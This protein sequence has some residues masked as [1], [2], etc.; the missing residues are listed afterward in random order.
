MKISSFIQPHNEADKAYNLAAEKIEVYTDQ[1]HEPYIVIKDS[2]HIIYFANRD[3]IKRLV[4]KWFIDKY[5]TTIRPSDVNTAL[6]TL[7]AQAE[8]CN[9]VKYVATR[10]YQK[11]DVIYYDLYNSN[12]TVKCNKE[13]VSVIN[14][15]QIQDFYFIRD[16]FQIPQ[17]I[18][19]LEVSSANLL[20]IISKHFNIAKQHS[21]LFAV[22]VCTAFIPNINHPI[23]IIEGEKGSGK[24]TMCRNLLNIINPTKKELLVMPNDTNNLVTV[25]SNNYLACFDN[26]GA[27]GTEH[28]NT[29]CLAVTG[30]T[31]SKRKLYT[32][33]AEISINIRRIVVLNGLALQIAQSDLVDRSIM[34]YLNRISEENR[35]TESNL[36]INFARDLPDLL[37]SIFNT[38]SKA[39]SL[40][41]HTKLNN[42]PRM[43]DFCAIGYCIA[44]S[45]EE[46]KGE[47]F[48]KD[49]AD[50]IKFA[51]ESIVGDNPVLE[52]IK[53][54]ADNIGYWHS[55]MSEL[56]LKM[57]SIIENTHIDRRIPANFPKNPS[58]LSRKLNNYQHD[59]KTLGISV[60]I[61]RTTDR[62]VTIGS[63]ENINV[64]VDTDET[65][66]IEDIINFD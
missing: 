62:Y 6:E 41:G 64:A 33:N 52:C 36:N 47:Q 43:A 25:L 49:Y 32:D 45:I 38:I 30:G 23:L 9:D 29:L 4:I 12:K 39:L 63:P 13:N 40:Y 42:L 24:S 22:C 61:G 3:E 20:D 57:R 8:N 66:D 26:I 34:L 2:K 35:N 53:Y 58:A 7:Y 65:D 10:I 21:L 59:L 16:N 14:E 60:E 51:T 1:N 17:C 37:G 28:S 27:L 44:E 46:G 18:P 5:K 54:I 55:T 50:N 15:T 48:I 19:N 31:L 11:D 56:L